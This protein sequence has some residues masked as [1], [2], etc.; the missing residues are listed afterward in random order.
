MGVMFV[1]IH[2]HN[3]PNHVLIID[4]YLQGEVFTFTFRAFSRRFYP[5]R[6]T[7]VNTH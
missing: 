7:S 6:L 2:T 1:S 4:C 5:K 3:Q